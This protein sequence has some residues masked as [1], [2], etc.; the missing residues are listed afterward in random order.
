MWLRGYRRAWLG[1]D[2]VAGAVASCVVIPQAIAYASLAGL[3]VELGLYAALVLMVVYALLGQLPPAERQRHLDDLDHH[4]R[5]GR[6][7]GRS[8]GH[9]R[10]PRPAGRRLPARAGL[11]RLGF[12]ADLISLPILTG[13]KAGIGLVI[14]TSQ[15]GKVL[16]IPVDG[17]GFFAHVADLLRGL[18]DISL[19]LARPRRRDDRAARR[20]PA[21]RCRP[22]PRRSSPSPPASWPSPCSSPTSTWSAPSPPVSR[23][24]RC[25]ASTAG[26]RSC[27]RRAASR[28][29]PPSSR[30]RRRARSP[31]ATTRRSTPNR[32]L[33]ALGAANLA[34]GLFQAFPG[35][36]GLSQ[37]AV[38]DGAGART[39][40][41]SH[42][43]RGRRGA[44]PHGAHR[45]ARRPRAGDARRARRR[46]RRRPGA[47]RGAAPD[48]ARP[49][50]RLPAR[51]RRARRRA[52]AGRA[53]R[54]HGRRPRL[55][56]RPVLPGEPAA[57]GRRARRGR[58]ARPAP[59]GPACTSRTSGAPPS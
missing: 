41:A 33:R 44:R 34:G 35:G 57:G 55:D 38:Q 2:V 32:E 56:R 53:G 4:R 17:D 52:R 19:A 18:D 20:P 59:A 25:R 22:C 37:S 47:P 10:P 45:T 50:A 46:G 29:W 21:A 24:S 30:S 42:R 54:D 48:R 12:L 13:Y 26:A 36:G 14:L 9:R 49:H 8:G 15:L 39:Q 23:R 5:R 27:R 58:R 43:L 31:G 16:G 11:V 7:L 28:S 6:R 3:P 40:L 51:A 1:R